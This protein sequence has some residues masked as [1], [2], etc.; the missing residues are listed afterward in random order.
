MASI[1]AMSSKLEGEEALLL[2][3]TADLFLH[4]LPRVLRGIG[5]N[6]NMVER[7][8]Q[9]LEV[10]GIFLLFLWVGPAGSETFDPQEVTGHKAGWTF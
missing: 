4:H 9:F 6:E 2:H 5:I 3:V 8:A 7:N 1:S 10:K